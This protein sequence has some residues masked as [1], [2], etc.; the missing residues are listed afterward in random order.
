MFCCNRK[1]I[2]YNKTFCCNREKK[3]KKTFSKS[4]AI[5]AL[6]PH[7]F[8]SFFSLPS[9]CS[10]SFPLPLWFVLT[11]KH[12]MQLRTAI[13]RKAHSTDLSLSPSPSST[14]P[15]PYQKAKSVKEN[16]P[17][18]DPNSMAYDLKQSPATAMKLK[19]QLPPRPP[20]SN[21]LK[22]KLIMETVP[23]N[24]VPGASDSDVQVFLFANPRFW[25]VRWEVWILCV[26]LPRKRN[27]TMSM[28]RICLNQ[29]LEI[30]WRTFLVNMVLSP[31][32]GNLNV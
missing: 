20:S 19:S 13:L 1:K 10:L 32:M 6:P 12:F 18:S 21:P 29:E 26:W 23:E 16:A 30:I 9:L 14:K 17:P 7:Q 24:S 4:R 22:K 8:L 5:S 15:R 28:S 11:M 2:I 27:S 31:V 3:K 25:L